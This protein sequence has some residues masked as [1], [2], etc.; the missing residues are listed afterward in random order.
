[1][2]LLVVLESWAGITCPL[3]TREQWLREWSAGR[4]YRGDFIANLV[5]D[6]LFVDAPPWAFTL[7]DS[8][9]GAAVLSGYW[10]VPPRRRTRPME[11]TTNRT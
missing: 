6:G 5:H 3:T 8:L 2:I 10:C 9:L 7:V 4:T 1:L 11:S